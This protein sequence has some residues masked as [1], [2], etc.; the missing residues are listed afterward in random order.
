MSLR[1]AEVR[2][3]AP[4]RSADRIR[5]WYEKRWGIEEFFRLLKSGARIEA[6]HFDDAADLVKCLAF[7]AA[8]AWRVLDLHRVARREP[9]RLASGLFDDERAIVQMM[10]HRISR[11]R[12]I[13]PPPGQTAA[14]FMVDLGRI[15]GFRPTK[16]QPLPGTGILW[17]AMK[18]LMIAAQAI[19]SHKDHR[20][21][22]TSSYK[23]SV[24]SV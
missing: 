14:E 10:A 2:I 21:A 8:A 24:S 16:K 13:R 23:T 4:G 20:D 3:K 5:Q 22:E 11:K 1:I 17:K 18:R 9:D 19:S 15:G 6:R 7:D 12:P